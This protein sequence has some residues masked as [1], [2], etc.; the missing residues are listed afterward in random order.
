MKRAYLVG[1]TY[2][3][4]AGLKYGGWKWD[5]GRKAW[6]KDGEWEDKEHVARCVHLLPGVRNRCKGSYSVE[7]Q[8]LRE[9]ETQ[10]FQQ[11]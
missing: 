3:I 4:R 11:F 5:A 8:S 1:D 9:K 6:Y 2:K 7:L 10:E